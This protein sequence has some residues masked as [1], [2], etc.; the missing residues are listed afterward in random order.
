MSKRAARGH[1]AKQQQHSLADLPSSWCQQLLSHL[2]S[3]SRLSL[4]STCQHFLHI[5]DMLVD[6]GSPQHQSV[7]LSLPSA[8]PHPQR[9]SHQHNTYSR[10]ASSST[11]GWHQT[12]LVLRL[13]RRQPSLVQLHELGLLKQ[14]VVLDTA[15]A[16]RGVLSIGAFDAGQIAVRPSKYCL[17][18]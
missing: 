1:A 17:G 9:I 4:R 16:N 6:S 14:V 2:S 8:Q 5:C 13:A 15:G 3:S 10:T 18:Q 12:Q 7:V 11:R